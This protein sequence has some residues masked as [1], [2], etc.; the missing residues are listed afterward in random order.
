MA[1]EDLTFFIHAEATR[2]PNGKYEPAVSVVRK[3]RR[4][5][6]QMPLE[7]EERVECDTEEEAIALG[8]KAAS[9]ALR[10]RYP[11]AEIRISESS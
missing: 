5:Y 4:H 10:S 2:L 8:Q 7:L 6:S 11:G 9:S 3:L 1:E